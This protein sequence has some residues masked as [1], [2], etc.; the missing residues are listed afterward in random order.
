MSPCM[1]P[2]RTVAR[3][4]E[5]GDRRHPRQQLLLL[6]LPVVAFTILGIVGT[7]LT[8]E[9]APR[10][11]LALIMLEARD[12]NLLAARHAAFVPFVVIGTIRRIVSDPF[13]YL[14]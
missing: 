10:H 6:A 11:P 2:Q 9:L 12:R 13:F 14:M 5:T 4:D 1:T 8:P 7:I 3:V